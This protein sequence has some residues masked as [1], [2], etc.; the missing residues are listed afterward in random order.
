M[1]GETQKRVERGWEARGVTCDLWIDPPNQSCEDFVHPVDELLMLL[2]GKLELEM[3]GRKFCSEV[4]ELFIPAKV[5][6]SVPNV[7]GT[8]GLWLYG[9]KKITD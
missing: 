9:Y 3:Q 5:S 8:T 7:G 6:R 2:Q 4:E 1:T